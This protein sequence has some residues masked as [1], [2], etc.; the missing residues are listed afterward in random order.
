MHVPVWNNNELAVDARAYEPAIKWAR[1]HAI[2]RRAGNNILTLS[3]FFVWFECEA[4]FAEQKD[5]L[6]ACLHLFDQQR[7]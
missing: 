4:L 7:T 6:Q 1:M 5:P 3:I 2:K